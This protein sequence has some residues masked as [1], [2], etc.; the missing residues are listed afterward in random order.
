MRELKILGL[1]RW[2]T[3][4][5][6]LEIKCNEEEAF[7]YNIKESDLQMFWYDYNIYFPLY[8]WRIKSELS[9][10]RKISLRLFRKEE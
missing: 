4:R 7:M 6:P 10:I 2:E 9:V 1:L 5:Q 8:M 3:D